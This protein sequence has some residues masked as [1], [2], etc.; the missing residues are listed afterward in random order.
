VQNRA[1]AYLNCLAYDCFHSHQDQ[2]ALNDHDLLA[3]WNSAEKRTKYVAFKKK[4][5]DYPVI[6]AKMEGIKLDLS[7]SQFRP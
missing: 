2:L 4:L 1:E 7:D 3:E 6:V 5:L